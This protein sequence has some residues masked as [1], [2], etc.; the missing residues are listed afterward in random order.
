MKRIRCLIGFLLSAFILCN[1]IVETQAAGSER[2]RILVIDSYSYAED[3]TKQQIAGIEKVID[4]WHIVDYQFMNA[5][6]VV[7]NESLEMFTEMLSYR[8]SSADPYNVIVVCGDT[9]LSFALDHQEDLFEGLPIVFSGVYS[10]A[11]AERAC[12]NPLVSGILV[13]RGYA[14]NIELAL[15]FHPTAKKVVAI[16]DNTTTGLIE[17]ENFYACQEQFPE[18]EFLE[19]NA[20]ENY[21]YVLQRQFRDMTTD[22]IALFVSMTEDASGKQYSAAD[23]GPFIQKYSSVPV[24]RMEESRI[25]EVAVSRVVNTAAR[26]DGDVTVL[27]DVEIVVNDLLQSR[28]RKQDGNME[29]LVLR[30]RLD[31]N[32]D[33]RLVLFF[34]DGNILG[35]VL[36]VK[37]SVDAQRIRPL[38]NVVQIGDLLQK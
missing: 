28:L 12:K 2:G 22:S 10:K 25:G 8:L 34:Y 31:I 6:T 11:L 15:S 21:T 35:I 19:I 13:E 18:L 38:R 37:I 36:S 26:D 3:S 27:S 29:A 33:S 7:D 20:S 17:R 5:K 23:I 9:A 24:Y 32:I 16:F 30:P 4:G 14:E 1:C